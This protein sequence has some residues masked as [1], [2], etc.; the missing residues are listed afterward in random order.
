MLK[1][2]GNHSDSPSV[3]E[4]SVC[5]KPL[6]VMCVEQKPEGTFCSA[7]CADARRLQLRARAASARSPGLCS[8]HPDSPAVARCKV[9]EKGVCLF[10]IVETPEGSFCSAKCLQVLSE[11]KGWVDEPKEAAVPDPEPAP[12][13]EPPPAAPAWSRAV[14]A[15]PEVPRPGPKRTVA[16]LLAAAVLGAVAV[17]A[18]LATTG[19]VEGPPI[20]KKEPPRADPPPPPAPPPPPPPP[21]P[22]PEPVKPEPPPAPK[23]EPPKPPP[24][25]PP[26]E[27]PPARHLVRAADPWAGV[28]PGAWYRVKTSEGGRESF[29]DL[30]LKERGGWYAVVVTQARREK[31]EA[32]Q[33]RWIEI[34]AARSTG[35]LKLDPWEVDLVAI[36][37]R[38]SEVLWVVRDGPHAGVVLKRES[39]GRRVKIV[40]MEPETLTVKDR[41]F[42]CLRVDSEEGGATVRRWLS[43]EIPLAAV[44]TE[45][46]GATETLVDFGSDWSKRPPFPAPPGPVAKPPVVP[47]PPPPPKPVPPPAPVATPVPPP[48]PPPPPPPKEEPE[49]RRKKMMV[50]AAAKLRDATPLYREVAAVD[51]LPAESAEL[52]ALLGRAESAQ[53]LLREARGIYLEAKPASDDPAILDR[54]VS[55]IDSLLATLGKRMAEIEAVLR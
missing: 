2:C 28:P 26:M 49:D 31:P 40:K 43:P 30:G 20:V 41:A 3:S 46:E 38:E 55:Q 51:P 22:K 27:D 14:P 12:E 32:E 37:G 34:G 13:P 21:E 23:P 39:A 19:P 29:T 36:Q 10:C 50:D 52:K 44:K 16:L 35:E 54:R 5:A 7:S 24:P 15:E 9:C 11:V 45:R 1:P 42:P 18:Y 48:K 17:A 53:R 6:C 33:H 47:P 8:N 4:C 25:P